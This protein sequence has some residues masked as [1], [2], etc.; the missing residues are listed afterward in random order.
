MATGLGDVA[1]VSA[2]ELRRFLRD[3]PTLLYSIGLP[4][5]L[6]PA[7]FLG[8]NQV[9]TLAQGAK[10]RKVAQ[11]GIPRTAG[12]TRLAGSFALEKKV[13]LVAIP[14]PAGGSAAETAASA[15]KKKSLD[16]LIDPRFDPAGNLAAEVYY[17][18]ARDGSVLARER[19]EKGFSDFRRA[20]LRRRGVEAGIAEPLLDPPEVRG[21]DITPPER[22]LREAM[23]RI[24]PLLLLLMTAIGGLY[25]ALDATVGERERGTIETTL[26]APVGRSALI[27]GKY[28]PVAALAF[29]SAALNFT[30]MSFA[31]WFFL[32]GAKPDLLGRLIPPAAVAVGL[33]AAVLLALFLGAVLC[34]VALFARSFKEGQSY[35]GPVLLLVV[36]PGVASA[37][38]DIT[39]T[40][41]LSVTPL[42]N[43]A[44][45]LRETLEERL[46]GRFLGLVL[47]SSV[48]Y[49]CL[50]ILAA[51]RLIRRE[52]VLLGAPAAPP[53]RI[54]A[55]PGRS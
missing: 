27:I 50:A 36:A 32:L 5:F 6:Y 10:E 16:A 15:I 23:A 34:A 53:R 2:G 35:L 41:L 26:L 44:L 25:P 18:S 42:L 54:A 7:L 1:R 39:L 47:V 9:L 40:P 24:L 55:V 48:L 14:D 33:G 22:R 19:I 13:R 46:D 45:L 28:L 17:S 20:E 3:G 11:V 4:L 51:S 38:P 30:S 43:L 12:E 21:V 52:T 31:S 29:L 8:L 49:T 37:V